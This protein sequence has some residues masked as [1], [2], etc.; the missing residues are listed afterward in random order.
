MLKGFFIGL[1]GADSRNKGLH[2][3]NTH[4]SGT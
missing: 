4:E 3:G 1:G 2:S